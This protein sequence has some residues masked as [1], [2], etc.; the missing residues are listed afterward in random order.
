MICDRGSNGLN[1]GA[2]TTMQAISE[3]DF[4][5]MLT[6][7]EG[8]VLVDFWADWCGPCKQIGPA[9]EEIST[10]MN[11]KITEDAARST[12]YGMLATVP[13]RRTIGNVVLTYCEANLDTA[14][15]LES[16]INREDTR[17]RREEERL[18]AKPT[19]L[20]GSKV[21]QFLPKA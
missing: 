14:S 6:E 17:I 9:L 19:F 21:K 4:D 12:M 18:N 15:G 16:L 10:E 1:P 2:M 8:L 11:G 5:Q 3:N 7:A 13:D 20:I